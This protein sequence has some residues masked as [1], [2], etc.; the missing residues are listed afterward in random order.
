MYIYGNYSYRGI[1]HTNEIFAPDKMFIWRYWGVGVGAYTSMHSVTITLYLLLGRKGR[2]TIHLPTEQLQ[3]L[4]EQGYTGAQMAKQL[5][6]SPSLLYKKLHRAGL[7]IRDK[8]S[9]I[10]DQVL[11][12]Q[13][14]DLNETFPNSGTEVNLLI[15]RNSDFVMQIKNRVCMQAC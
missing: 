6:C 9:H 4:R 11:H 8:Y 15:L 1:L 5:K 12:T 13:I 10:D 14:K 7:H 3:F 2:P